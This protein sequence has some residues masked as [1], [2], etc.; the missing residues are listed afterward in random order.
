MIYLKCA[1][2]LLNKHLE[3]ITHHFSI[4]KTGKYKLDEKYS[5]LRLLIIYV[6]K[7]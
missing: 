3:F 7:E 4:I 6:K 1:L 2:R 5:C